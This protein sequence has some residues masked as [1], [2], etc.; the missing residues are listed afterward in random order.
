MMAEVIDDGHAAA[1][2]A[3]F[4]AAL[5]PFEGVEGRLDLGIF[6]PAMFGAGDHR[7]SVSHIQLAEEIQA[8][9]EARDLKFRRGRAESDV[10]GFYGIRVAETE[11]LN[12]AVGHVDQVGDVWIVTI[13]EQ[14]AVSRHQIDKA[15]EGSLDRAEVFEDVS[16]IELEIVYDHHLGEVMDELAP[17]IE[18]RSVIFIAF[19]DEPFAFGETSALA[20]IGRYPAYQE[21]RVEAVVLENPGEQGGSGSFAVSSGDDEGAF[22]PNEVF[23]KQLGQGA[24]AQFSFEHEFHFWIA[25][26]N[27]VPDDD[28]VGA[29]RQVHF[30]ITTHHLDLAVGQKRGHGGIDV[31]IGAS[32][33]NAFILKGRRG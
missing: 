9:L 16:V 26:G 21:A 13:G 14:K 23:L 29:M 24:V 27:C 15:F 22:A 6:Q 32:N 12:R 2:A 20:E 25:S 8:E 33:L 19:D 10:E 5:D 31:L 1:D 30:R 18:E 4:H 11:T 17:L 3:D 28:E 7:Q